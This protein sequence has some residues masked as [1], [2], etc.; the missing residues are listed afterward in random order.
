LIAAGIG[1][2]AVAV[3]AAWA[4]FRHGHGDASDGTAPGAAPAGSATRS[5][6]TAG[7]SAAAGAGTAGNPTERPVSV[8]VTAVR[9]EDVPIFLEGIGSVTALK[10]VTVKTQVDG[11]LDRVDFREG[12]AVRAGALLAQIDPRPFTILRHQAEAALA[13]DRATLQSNRLNLERY[14]AV[15]KENLIA[16][17]QVDDQRATVAQ[18]EAAIQADQA[19]LEQANLQLDYAHIRS[20]IDGVTGVRLVDPGNV[21]HAA[22]PGGL[23][24]VAQLD[25]VAVLFTLPQDDLPRIAAEMAKGPLRVDVSTRD[26]GALLG[27]GSLELIDN[28]INQTT[29]SIRLKAILPNPGRTLWP[30]QFV[31]ARLLLSVRKQ[32]LVVPAATIQRGPQGTFVYLVSQDQRA[33]EQRANIRPVQVDSLEGD[34]AV[35]GRGLA[36]GDSV[37]IEGQTQLR[38]G[39]RVA[40]KS[41]DLGSEHGPPSGPDHPARGG[42]APQRKAGGGPPGG[43]AGE[44]PAAHPRASS[45]GTP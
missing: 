29:A 15:R 25:P 41:Q 20:P 9:R 34:T 14:I 21:V 16:Q 39:A 32:A 1:L 31:K 37:V 38:P 22:D 2:G 3:V 7:T 6:A 10:T 23:V 13:R 8:L 19:Q 5:P 18:L 30:N 45:T 27:S 42:G 40:A 4:L 28:Q 43:A 17:Q 36:V 24:V 11:R 12:Q 44:A 33:Q 35:I 26:G